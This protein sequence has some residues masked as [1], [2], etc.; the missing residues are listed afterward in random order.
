MIQD[1]NRKRN[2]AISL[3]R[4][5]GMLSIVL[6]LIIK[7][8]SFIPGHESLGTL[9]SSGVYLFFFISGFLYSTKEIENYRTWYIKRISLISLPATITAMCTIAAIAISGERIN[10]KSIFAYLFDLEGLL[11]INWNFTESHLFTEIRSLGS[12]WFTTII[13]LCYLFLPI[14]GHV[15]KNLTGK[16]SLIIASV[17]FSI[18]GLSAFAFLS[19]R[20]T[21]DYLFIFTFGYLFGF[22]G[23]DKRINFK[24]F[25]FYTFITAGVFIF[26]FYAKS[27][28]SNLFFYTGLSTFALA[29]FGIWVVFFFFLI[30]NKAPQKV[31]KIALAKPT[32]ILDG[33]SFYVYL[34][35]GIFC[36]GT[37]DLYQKFKLFPAT[38]LFLFSTIISA[39]VL[40]KL[41]TYIV[42]GMSRPLLRS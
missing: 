7:Y 29:L 31:T 14:L 5:T 40:K 15:K 4:I 30:Q 28:L 13:M 32:V 18:L 34:T 17:T 11:F 21:L 16:K 23:S 12:L 26:K 38:V 20:F 3:A 19:G 39:I 8:Y 36:M 6:C 41:S 1:S 42:K 25:S 35:H 22:T 33:I 9:F 24:T 37:F 27:K 2:S 10:I